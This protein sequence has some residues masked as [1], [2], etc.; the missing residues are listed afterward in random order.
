MQSKE[1]LNILL[2]DDE[3]AN[4]LVLESILEKLDENLVRAGSGEEALRKVLD[5]DFTAILLDVRMPGLDG[6]QTARLIRS[7]QRSRLTPILFLTAAYDADFS[8]KEA[9]SLGAIDCLTKPIIPEVLHAKVAFF[10]ELRRKTDELARVEQERLTSSLHAKDERLRLILDNSRDYAFIFTDPNGLVV[11][12]EGAAQAITGWSA[13]DMLG[14]STAVLFKPEDRAADRPASEL[15]RAKQ[16]G[17]AEDK[18]WHLR[19]NGS[20]FFADGVTICLYDESSRHHGFAKI[21][22][23]ATKE[24]MA[25]D[26]VRASDE[27]LRATFMSM[28]DGVIATDRFGQVTSLNSVAQGLTGW[29]QAEARGKP[30]AEVFRIRSEGDQGQLTGD[31][32]KMLSEGITVGALRDDILIDRDGREHP[33]EDRAALIRGENGEMLG[34]VLTIRDVTEKKRAAAQQESLLKEVQAFKRRL[35]ELF[36]QAP[37]LMAVLRGAQHAFELANDHYMQTI[38][39]REIL[40]RSVREAL[41]ELEGQD[42]FERL[43]QVY[44]TGEPFIGTEVLV[45]FQRS[46][47]QPLEARFLDFVYLPLRDANGAVSGILLHGVDL[48]ERKRSKILA[49]GQTEALRLAIAGAEL[50]EVLETLA[51]AAEAQAGGAVVASILLYGPDGKHLRSV[52]APSL[53]ESY[54]EL[55]TG[56]AAELPAGTWSTALCGDAELWVADIQTDPLWSKLHELAQAQGLHSCWSLPILSSEGKGMGAFVLYFRESRVPTAGERESMALLSNTA[57]LVIDRQSETRKRQ[58][59]EERVRL[60]TAAAEMA[61]WSWDPAADKVTWENDRAYDIFGLTR[62]AQ[63]INESTLLTKFIQ[64]EYAQA[65]RQAATATL[66]EGKRFYF[67]GQIRRTN[68]ELRWVE[69]IGRLRPENEAEPLR[70]IGTVSDITERKKAENELRHL[71]AE[72]SAA[73]R[74]KTEFLATL[75]HELRNPLAPLR[76]G[77]QVMRLAGDEPETQTKMQDLMDR[78]LTH[79]VHLID[80]LLD[81]AR[82]SSGKVNLKKQRIQLQG[83]LANAVEACHALIQSKEHKLTVDM[84]E[85][86]LLLDADP[87][88]MAQVVSNLLNNAAKYTPTGGRIDLSVYQDADEAVIS[89]TDTGVGLAPSSLLTVFEMFSQVG[90]TLEQAQGGLGI[91]LSLVRRL[92]ALHNGKVMAV[93]PGLGQGSTFIVRLPLAPKEEPAAPSAAAPQQTPSREKGAM[94]CLKVLVV[95]DNADAAD[96]LAS[97]LEFRGHTMRVAHDGEQALKVAQEFDPDLVF[98]DIGM[99]G[100]NGYEVA[101]QLR[102]K[103][104]PGTSRPVLVAVTGWGTDADRSLSSEAGF[105]HHLTKPAEFSDIDKLL[106]MLERGGGT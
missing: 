96:T 68:G 55:V 41:P 92:V 11:E 23:D 98:L 37:A 39:A 52:A 86:A 34:S 72:L 32:E 47:G 14:Q 31:T 29:S 84:P 1:R 53:P 4:L 3:P 65:F 33:V 27:L 38:G 105:A 13:E 7:R 101:R 85:E 77:L 95:D 57:A 79:M 59:A 63:L 70:V 22:R 26:A 74:R 17:R 40:G 50:A 97:L 24:R 83:V 87:T 10:V 48:T 94:N 49:A 35:E 30:L 69:V 104:G 82:I 80:D 66:K 99:P 58:E 88:R 90:R 2:V 56:M 42:F 8:M 16:T 54:G 61:V 6:F 9:Y 89:V 25:L 51:R 21:F 76:N 78:Q 93:S 46:A 43:D 12:W 5:H 36:K 20:L 44:Q 19:R 71:A 60:A 75:A 18:Q 106:S 103:A 45:R 64:P 67:E 100:K 81:I 91:G 15:R 73:D 28:G 62:S 102:S